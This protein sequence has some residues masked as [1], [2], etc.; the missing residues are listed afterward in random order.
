MQIFNHL[1]R[2]PTDDTEVKMKNQPMPV[3]EE[4]MHMGIL[5]SADT[6]ETAVAYNIQNWGKK[7]CFNL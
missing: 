2:C 5:H 3:D 4:A 6:K 1:K 7:N